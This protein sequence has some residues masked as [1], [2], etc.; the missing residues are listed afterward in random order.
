MAEN[1]YGYLIKKGFLSLFLW[2]IAGLLIGIL[3]PLQSTIRSSILPPDLPT[4]D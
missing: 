3:I 2:N 4:E 1:T